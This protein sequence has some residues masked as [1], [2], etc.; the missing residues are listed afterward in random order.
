MANQ[1]YANGMEIACK[2]AAG[3]SMAAFPDTCLS[4]PSPPAGPL[5]VPYPNTAFAS[6]TTNG[7]TTV[8]ISGQEVMLKDQSTFKKS[9]GNEAATKSLG[10]GV[11]THTIQGEASFIAWSMDV[12]IE[13]QNVDRHLDL[14]LHNEQCTTTNTAP[15]VYVDQS[16]FGSQSACAGD[17]DK[18]ETACD[19]QKRKCP[20]VLNVAK[21]TQRQQMGLA[22]NERNEMFAEFE[23]VVDEDASATA[24][25]AAAAEAQADADECVKRAR[26]YLR[27]Y[28]P[29]N[30]QDG[31][32]PGQTGHH[33][34]PKA[35]FK[36][37][38]GRYRG[39]Y[40]PSSALVVCME[41][42]NQHCG[43]HGKNHAAIEYIAETVYG[44]AVD[45]PCSAKEYNSICATAVA[46]QCGCDKECI[47]AQ[48]NQQCKDTGVDTVTHVNTA[49]SAGVTPELKKDIRGVV[50]RSK[51]KVS[52]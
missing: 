41:G 12:K 4:P 50:L 30:D 14:M 24:R 22:A 42:M 49:S 13:G 38:S 27:P 11:V 23:D 3:K 16:A 8:M 21:K 28:E 6:D 33:I 7:S 37:S 31:C 40:S 52:V 43:S 10:M 39:G 20:G 34:P 25:A 15:F 47:E 1:V 46:A 36:N 29:K 5:P 44:K 17:K 19:G 48:L 45:K 51:V 26:C 18:M 32:C 35:C 2:A 9:T